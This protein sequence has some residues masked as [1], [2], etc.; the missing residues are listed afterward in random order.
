MFSETFKAKTGLGEMYINDWH[1][2]WSNI[3]PVCNKHI[4]YAM[5]SFMFCWLCIS[6]ESCK[7]K[8]TWC[9]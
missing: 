3:S 2:E 7:A 8:P 4:H 5:D 1:M 6:T 9:I